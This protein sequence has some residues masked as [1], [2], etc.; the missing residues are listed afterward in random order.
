MSVIV[1]C[2]NPVVHKVWGLVK[3]LPPIWGLEDSVRGRGVGEDKVQFFFQN[4]RDLYHVLTRGP[5]FVNGWIVSLDQWSPTPGPDF[6]CKI[7]FWIRIRGILVHLLKKQ[8]IEFLLGPLGKVEKVELHAKNSSSVEYVRA[9]VW[10]N[11]EEPL[12]FRRIARFK[13][14]EVVPTELEYEKLIKVC[15]MCKR[16]T[17]DR[18]YCPLQEGLA[19]EPPTSRRRDEGGS[20][21]S[22]RGKQ[23]V[24][25]TG[26]HQ[27]CVAIAR[28]SSTAAGSG[29]GNITSSEQTPRNSGS[30]ELRVITGRKG[31]GIR[32]GGS[33]GASQTAP[34]V[35]SRLGEKESTEAI[36]GEI[37]EGA[38]ID[39]VETPSVFERLGRKEPSSSSGKKGEWLDLVGRREG[40]SVRVMRDFLKR[41]K[42]EIDIFLEEEC[43]TKLSP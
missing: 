42:S 15:F 1:R 38:H 32:G 25:R 23:N 17:H 7:P 36:G 43:K 40:D 27:R 39:E 20:F 2:L 41:L 31:K 24:P 11:T 37:V 22:G 19:A 13:S 28:S 26:T 9:Q 5:W 12:Q 33:S 6:L 21:E 3:A 8:A 14:G 18:L 10:I 34:S 35:F 4:E 16:L 30:Q 29:R